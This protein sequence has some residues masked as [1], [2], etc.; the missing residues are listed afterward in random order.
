MDSSKMISLNRI[1]ISQL[2]NIDLFKYPSCQDSLSVLYYYINIISLNLNLIEEEEETM[3]VNKRIIVCAVVNWEEK[4]RT[5]VKDK[6]KLIL[7]II[8]CDCNDASL[9]D[10]RM[11]SEW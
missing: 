5:K 4:L 11:E 10:G 3:I 8:I 7:I 2:T 1:N 6:K 9:R